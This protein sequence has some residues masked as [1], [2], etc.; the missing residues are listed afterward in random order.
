MSKPLVKSNFPVEY[1]SLSNRV[2]SLERM[3][4]VLSST[5]EINTTGLTSEQID[6]AVIAEGYAAPNG[7]LISDP[8]NKLLLIRQEN[9]WRRVS[10]T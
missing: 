8:T 7:K 3:I 2:A 9:V 5:T 6:S 4:R 10:V 1:K